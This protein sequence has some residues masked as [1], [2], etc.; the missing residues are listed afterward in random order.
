MWHDNDIRELV[1]SSFQNWLEEY[2][3]ALES[4]Q[5]VFHE[6]GGIVKADSIWCV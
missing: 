3:T 5:Y 4:G 6:Y 2:A 1:A